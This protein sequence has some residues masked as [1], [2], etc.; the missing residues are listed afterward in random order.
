MRLGTMACGSRQKVS[1]EIGPLGCRSQAAIPA[2]FAWA[3]VA[4][5][6]A[7]SRYVASVRPGVGEDDPPPDRARSP[8]SLACDRR[9]QAL[10]SIRCPHELRRIHERRLELDDEQASCRGMPREDV[11]GPAFTVDGVRDFGQGYPSRESLEADQDRT[12]ER[13]VGTVDESIEL[14]TAPPRRDLQ[15]HLQRR[16]DA[17]DARE[18]RRRE[19]AAFQPTDERLR[20]P[21]SVGDLLLR[22]A[23]PDADR[24]KGR[25]DLGVLHA[26]YRA[27]RP[28]PVDDRQRGQDL[29]HAPDRHGGWLWPRRPPIAPS[30]PS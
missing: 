13:R 22:A 11:D 6:V 30:G 14:D 17:P 25:T 5:I 9:S 12:L 15:P 26:A 20:H 18:P 7:V 29:H 28:L 1:A 16:R 19:L 27:R 23:M 3:S 21:G 2:L 10:T 24:A 8:A 4:R